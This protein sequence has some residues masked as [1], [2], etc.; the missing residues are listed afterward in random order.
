M[1]DAQFALSARVSVVKS[2]NVAIFQ[3]LV[4]NI[5][6]TLVRGGHLTVLMSVVKTRNARD[7]NVQKT[8][9]KSADMGVSQNQEGER[10]KAYFPLVILIGLPSSSDL[11]VLISKRAVTQFA[12][13][14]TSIT[15]SRLP[16]VAQIGHETFNL[17]A[18]P[19]I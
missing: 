14:T 13:S 19:A 7:V 15:S 1:V 11:D 18:L 10:Q 12:I 6:I 3:A 4:R 9:K 5:E 2:T 17:L 8:Q 16:L